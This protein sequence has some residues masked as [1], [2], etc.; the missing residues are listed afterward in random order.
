[1]RKLCFLAFFSIVVIMIINGCSSDNNPNVNPEVYSPVYPDTLYRNTGPFYIEVSVRDPQGLDDI[2]SVSY[3]LDHPASGT[4]GNWINL[5]DSG[6]GGDSTANDSRYSALVSGLVSD[7]S[8]GEYEVRFRAVDRSNHYSNELVD[9]FH[10]PANE[11]PDLDSSSVHVPDTLYTDRTD[12]SLIT[13]SVSDPNGNDQIDSVWFEIFRPDNSS[14]G[15]HYYMFDDGTNGGDAIAGD[16][17]YSAKVSSADTDLMLGNF[18]FTF[19]AKDDVGAVSLPVDIR[20]HVMPSNNQPPLLLSINAPDTLFRASSDTAFLFLE[21]NDPQGLD[22][23]AAVWFDSYRPNGEK[24]AELL[25]LFDDGVSGLD[26]VAGDGIYSQYIPSPSNSTDSGL[27]RFEFNANDIHGA[28]ADSL[29]KYI[30]ITD[31]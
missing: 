30:L 24:Q 16:S 26:S 2:N 3:R 7:D 1:M 21:V 27:W 5:F 12:S 15:F 13:I 9:S 23:I 22:N 8:T 31:Q 25:P 19:Y 11:L 18:L 17:V 20:V 4:Q 14:N 6:V 10:V 29:D 28:F